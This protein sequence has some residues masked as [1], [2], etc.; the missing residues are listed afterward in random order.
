[1]PYFHVVLTIPEELN[2]LVLVN[3][4]ALYAILFRAGSETLLALG[5]DPKRVWVQKLD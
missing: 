2:P 4:K 1:M 5:N 3:Q